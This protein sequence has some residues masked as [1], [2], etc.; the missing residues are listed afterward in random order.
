MKENEKIERQITQTEILSI[1]QEAF[2]NWGA[3]ARPSSK[4]R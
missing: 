2:G 1:L 4:E 3:S